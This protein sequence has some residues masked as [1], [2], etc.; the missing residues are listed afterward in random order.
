[1]FHTQKMEQWLCDK[2]LKELPSRGRAGTEPHRVKGTDGMGGAAMDVK[3]P[4]R[5]LRTH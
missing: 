5:R 3:A 4:L 2:A 1:M